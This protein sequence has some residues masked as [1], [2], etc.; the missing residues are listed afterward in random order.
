MP[1]QPPGIARKQFGD[2]E[3]VFFGVSFKKM[4]LVFR[5]LHSQFH[6]FHGITLKEWREK[7][8][9]Q[10]SDFKLNHTKPRLPFFLR[11]ENLKP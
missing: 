2:A 5:Q 9:F 4:G 10:L 11:C 1:S 8:I 3:G 6:R 7:T